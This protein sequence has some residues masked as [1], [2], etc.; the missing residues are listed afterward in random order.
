MDCSY[1]ICL[2]DLRWLCTFLLIASLE[3]VAEFRSHG[4]LESSIAI[5]F[6]SLLSQWELNTTLRDVK[7]IQLMVKIQVKVRNV[8]MNKVFSD[9]LCTWVDSTN[10][11]FDIII[12]LVVFYIVNVSG[13]TS[14]SIFRILPVFILHILL[15]L[16]KLR[17]FT[18]MCHSWHT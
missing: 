1:W 17:N 15:R 10:I 11:I 6:Q 4:S 18:H 2:V 7:S 9:P 16:K 3:L 8:A 13:S 12:L 5:T 14:T